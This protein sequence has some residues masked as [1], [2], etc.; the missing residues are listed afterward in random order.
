MTDTKVNEITQGDGKEIKDLNIRVHIT[1][2]GM[3]VTPQDYAKELEKLIRPET[4]HS[5]SI[6]LQNLANIIKNS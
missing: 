6:L 2:S 4:S 3:E 5:I 1:V